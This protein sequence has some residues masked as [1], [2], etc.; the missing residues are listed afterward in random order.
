MLILATLNGQ[1]LVITQTADDG[2][3]ENSFNTGLHWSNGE[4]PSSAHDYV[5]TETLRTPVSSSS[6][7][8]QGKS[9]TLNSGGVLNYKGTGSTPYTITINS[10]TI[11]TGGQVRSEVN[12]SFFLAGSIFVNAGNV[13]T[14]NIASGNSGY[15]VTAAISGAG[16]LSLTSSNAAQS[17]TFQGANSYSGG[18]TISTANVIG[19][20]DSVFG[21]GD[22]TLNGGSLTLQSGALN[23][24]FSSGGRFIL[25][26]GLTTAGMVNLN[27]AGIDRLG[28]ISLNGGTTYLAASTYTAAQLNSLY[29]AN[30]FTGAGSLEVVPEPGAAGLAALVLGGL[31]L[32]RCRGKERANRR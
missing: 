8:F 7:V 1:A 14:F 9:L 6:F 4:A 23:D 21:T 19:G 3:G 28:G 31:A 27:F 32:R 29:G 11:N 18:T 26:S 12:R 15:V 10:L 2:S 25:A 5:T 16:G 20:A 24:Y 30:I 13:G 22:L 17:L